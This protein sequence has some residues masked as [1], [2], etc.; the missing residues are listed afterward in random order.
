MLLLTE[1]AVPKTLQLSR[2]MDNI[3]PIHQV[4]DIES[5]LIFQAT[6]PLAS[7]FIIAH[8]NVTGEKPTELPLYLPGLKDSAVVF[9]YS[10]ICVIVHAIIQEYLLDKITKKLHLSKSKLAVFSTSGQLFAFYLISAIWGLDI[11]KTQLQIY[12]H[13]TS[14]RPIKLQS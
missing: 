13:M 6:S 8:H 7:V 4:D 1:T 10:L 3:W 11:G 14:R 9:F 2:K 5:C 12:P